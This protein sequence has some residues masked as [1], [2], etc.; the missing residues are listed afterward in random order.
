MPGRRR[1][2]PKR[3][4]LP[5]QRDIAG[6]LPRRDHPRPGPQGADR[7]S[8][9]RTAGASRRPV[10]VVA[11]SPD[12]GHD[13]HSPGRSEVDMGTVV[14]VG[15]GSDLVDRLLPA[16]APG[17]AGGATLR[18]STRSQRYGADVNTAG[19][20]LGETGTVRRV[21]SRTGLQRRERQWDAGFAQNARDN[22]HILDFARRQREREAA[23]AHRGAGRGQLPLLPHAPHSLTQPLLR[24]APPPPLDQTRNALPSPCREVRRRR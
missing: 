8:V 12:H 4:N 1:A 9:A 21:S 2:P 15:G 13:L 11:F 18:A 5:G 10:R 6:R 24:D 22:A 7:K 20:M 16:P 14:E 3:A 17:A 19:R 23:A